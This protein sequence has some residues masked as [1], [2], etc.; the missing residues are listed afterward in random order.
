M[1]LLRSI[2]FN[3]LFYG[4]LTLRLLFWAPIFFFVR[5]E[6]G[7]WIVRN[8]ARSSLWLLE[9]VA[10]TSS[11]LSGLE[12]LP[13]GS[14]IVASKHQSVWEILS[15]LTVVERPTFIL[16]KELLS[17]PIFGAFAR[18]MK[19]IP[20]DR[21]K[22]GGAIPAM[23]EAARE[24][25][26]AGRRIIIF[27][28]G[29]RTRPGAEVEYRQGVYRLYEALG[30]PVVPVALNSGL[31]WPR[32]GFVKRPGTIRADFLEP[33]GPGL[34]RTRFLTTLRTAIETRSRELCGEAGPTQQAGAAADVPKPAHADPRFEPGEP[35]EPPEPGKPERGAQ[36][37]STTS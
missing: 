33:I 16:K 15:L 21:A 14:A 12:R 29:T 34:E 25:I 23:M 19:M 20:V 37:R 28:E 7:W 32:N 35:V 5:E 30:L 11:E 24:A 3:I 26:A 6:R 22:R 31:F 17:I 10:G 36:S 9:H 13:A 1:T 8:W 27:P 4:N 18:H 2:A